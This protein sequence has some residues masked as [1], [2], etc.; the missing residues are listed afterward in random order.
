MIYEILGDLNP[1]PLRTESCCLSL[2]QF[3]P[4]GLHSSSI[5]VPSHVKAL[6]L[7]F[8]DWKVFPFDTNFLSSFTIFCS[9]TTWW[10]FCIKFLPP[11]FVFSFPSLF[12]SMANVLL[13]NKLYVHNLVLLL[14]F[15]T[16]YIFSKNYFTIKV[17]YFILKK[18]NLYSFYGKFQVEISVCFLYYH[19]HSI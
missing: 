7:V 18:F 6:A 19:F 9:N 11:A 16:Y 1:V 17:Y 13:P 3:C 12:L 4:S 10:Q 5:S 14:L 2:L 8:F 15:L